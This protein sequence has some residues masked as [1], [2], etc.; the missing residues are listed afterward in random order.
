MSLIVYDGKGNVAM[1]DRG[2][3]STG[4]QGLYVEPITTIGDITIFQYNSHAP[5]H[6]VR[7][8]IKKLVKKKGYKK[9]PLPLDK[10]A[11]VVAK[12]NATLTAGEVHKGTHRIMIRGPCVSV[13]YRDP[14]RASLLNKQCTVPLS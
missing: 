5:A 3:L 11:K 12:W 2:P 13:N 7:R 14:R 4:G 10:L 9:K 8:F 6:L 1:F